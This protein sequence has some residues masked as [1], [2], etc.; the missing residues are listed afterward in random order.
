[1]ALIYTESFFARGDSGR[2]GG[3]GLLNTSQWR[4]DRVPYGIASVWHGDILSLEN[5]NSAIML[6]ETDRKRLYLTGGSGSFNAFLARSRNLTH[7]VHFSSSGT[8]NRNISFDFRSYLNNSA[9]NIRN[10]LVTLSL[11]HN[12]QRCA[13]SFATGGSGYP[14]IPSETVYYDMTQPVWIWV[15]CDM[16]NVYP[17]G[18]NGICRVWLNNDLMAVREGIYTGD[19]DAWPAQSLYEFNNQVRFSCSQD[20]RI[21]GVVS[22]NEGLSY[23]DSALG[24][25]NLV[26]LAPKDGGESNWQAHFDGFN[27][28]KENIEVMQ[29][30][31]FLN[32]GLL[33]T[34]EHLR[35][36]EHGVREMLMHNHPLGAASEVMAVSHIIT[37][38]KIGLG[39][40]GTKLRVEPVIH[41]SGRDLETRRT[42]GRES[43][44]HGSSFQANYT[45]PYAGA[46]W[47]KEILG[48]TSFGFRYFDAHRLALIQDGIDF[49]GEYGVE[50]IEECFELVDLGQDDDVAG[51]G[52]V[53]VHNIDEV[54][55]LEVFMNRT[56]A[57]SPIGSFSPFWSFPHY[58]KKGYKG[59]GDLLVVDVPGTYQSGEADPTYPASLSD[60]YANTQHMISLGILNFPAAQACVDRG[61]YLPAP[62]EY[63]ALFNNTVMHGKFHNSGLDEHFW[64]SRYNSLT[65]ASRISLNMNGTVGH[66]TLDVNQHYRVIGL[67]KP[68]EE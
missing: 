58:G 5:Y 37:H 39:S 17:G 16:A 45:I 42:G 60:G 28:E 59:P 43:F 20:Y 4:G 30:N 10:F 15:Q 61:L 3:D 35:A 55:D 57:L 27:L 62:E 24:D 9:T 1:M 22:L 54:I 40:E 6:N 34:L 32:Y 64:S 65:S 12:L 47:N 46:F 67:R 38:R 52:T 31:K 7:G 66:V 68:D 51:G 11:T 19:A 8:T 49:L 36:D 41:T 56:W 2:F 29:D 33:H 26:P 18:N 50:N 63:F 48:L 13:I 44:T 14:A 21:Y 53:K 23:M 25:I